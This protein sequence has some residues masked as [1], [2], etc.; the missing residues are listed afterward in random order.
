M[1]EFITSEGARLQFDPTDLADYLTHGDA[2]HA[3]LLVELEQ[4]TFQSVA[5]KR[6][7]LAALSWL[8]WSGWV[9]SGRVEI[10][11]KLVADLLEWG[12]GLVHCTSCDV[13][14]LGSDLTLRE[15]RFDGGDHREL[16]CPKGH[17]VLW[18]MRNCP[19]AIDNLGDPLPLPD[20]PFGRY[21]YPAKHTPNKW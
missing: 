8:T 3:A 11:E 16:Q 14:W 18:T 5:A 7:R 1:T 19:G 15:W 2:L 20:A 13:L 17:S 6:R 21:L 9:R 4:A 12:R 10:Q